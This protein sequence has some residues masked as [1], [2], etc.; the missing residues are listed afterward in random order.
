M[1]LLN[2]GLFIIVAMVVLVCFAEI[3]LMLWER[4]DRYMIRRADYKMMSQY[5]EN[6]VV[7]VNEKGEEYWVGYSK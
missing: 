6:P 2:C 3:F 4:I 5:M 7:M 1:I